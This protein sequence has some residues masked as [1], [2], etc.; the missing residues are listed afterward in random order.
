MSYN[1][2]FPRSLAAI[3]LYPGFTHEQFCCIMELE[4]SDEIRALAHQE[5]LNL[6]GEEHDNSCY[7]WYLSYASMKSEYT[8]DMGYA[9]KSRSKNKNKEP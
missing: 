7:R 5:W 8:R 6:Q 4:R 2:T 1:N 9:Y 3:G